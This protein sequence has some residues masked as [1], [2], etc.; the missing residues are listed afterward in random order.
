MKFMQGWLMTLVA[1]TWF[2]TLAPGAV[3]ETHHLAPSPKTVVRGYF[4]S[5]V[6]PV[7]RVR[8]GDTVEIETWVAGG[9]WA[10]ESHRKTAEAFILAVRPP[11]PP[12]T[13]SC[14]PRCSSG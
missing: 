7:L 13:L 3:A 2:G 11:A 1:T 5:S 14:V 10:L 8:S 12:Q 4:D 6:P 9:M